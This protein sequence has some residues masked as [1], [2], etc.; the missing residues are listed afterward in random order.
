M[1]RRRKPEPPLLAHASRLLRVLE[2]AHEAYHERIVASAEAHDGWAHATRLALIPTLRRALDELAKVDKLPAEVEAIP[3]RNGVLTVTGT[4]PAEGEPYPTRPATVG[5]MVAWLEAVLEP[6]SPSSEDVTLVTLDWGVARTASALRVPDVRSGRGTIDVTVE[7]GTA[8]ITATAHA[9]TVLVETHE[10]ALGISGELTAEVI[11][12]TV[13]ALAR[14][15]PETVGLER[16]LA[17]APVFTSSSI[18]HGL[19]LELGLWR[20]TGSLY[21]QP[22]RVLEPRGPLTVRDALGLAHVI[23]RWAD[24][25]YPEDRRV[26]ASENE[27]VG[28]F[29]YSTT[30]GRQRQLL[31]DAM[32]RLRATTFQSASRPERGRSSVLTWG[33]IESA[34]TPRTGPEGRVSITISEPLAYLVRIGSVAYLDAPTFAGLVAEDELAARLWVFLEAEELPWRWSLFSAPEGLPAVERETPAIADLLRIGWDRRR[35]VARRVS[36]AVTVLQAHD[37]RYRLSVERAPKGRGMWTLHGHGRAAGTP[38][39]ALG[40]GTRVL[41]D[42]REGTAG[43]ARRVLPDARLRSETAPTVVSL[44]SSITDETPRKSAGARRESYP[45]PSWDTDGSVMAAWR[46]R[47]PRPPT[48]KQLP[49]LAELVIRRDAGGIARALREAPPGIDPLK[50]VLGRANADEDKLKAEA[51]AE[52]REAKLKAEAVRTAPVPESAALEAIRERLPTER[53]VLEPEPEAAPP[54]E[55]E[56]EVAARRRA[57]AVAMLRAGLGGDIAERLRREHEITDE[58]LRD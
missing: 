41:P 19:Q 33:L 35:D 25:G 3:V 4:A 30:G 56:A 36:E 16:T 38:G 26:G 12:A 22:F 54:V 40:S 32:G 49:V 10:A 55:D 21:G 50:H 39:R 6:S 1:A 37:P 47:Y 9:P 2:D 17:R 51:E 14:Q 31:R 43:R 5:D 27:A 58:E 28:W 57:V 13:S 11:P 34:R 52:L 46:S 29:G 20:T 42:A 8:H 18:R 7:V 45:V 44:P 23:R 48:A 15:S 24:S 53:I